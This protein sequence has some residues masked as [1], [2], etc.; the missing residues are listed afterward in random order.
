[1][2]PVVSRIRRLVRRP[3]RL[4]ER[5]FRD[6]F[7][8]LVPPSYL[9]GPPRK[10]FEQVGNRYLRHSVELGGLRP[11]DRVLDVGSGVGRIAIPLTGYLSEKGGYEGFDIIPEQVEW[12]RKH[13]TPRYPNFRFQLADVHNTHYHPAGRFRADEY[14]FPYDDES[15]DFVI[16]TSVF[17]HMRP[18]EVRRY[19]SEIARVLRTGRCCLITWFLLNEESRRLIAEGRARRTFSHEL[20]G[21]H[22]D[23]ADSPEA[24]IAFEE[25]AVHDL[26]RETELRIVEPIHYGGWCGRKQPLAGQDVVIAE[27][28]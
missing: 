24:A 3:I 28:A 1:M 15:F 11:D 18:P 2:P 9:Y 4:T 19:L 12:C 16:L 14:R 5:V 20:N 7:T 25:T 6:V 23:D 22:T 17:T 26:Y 21:F 10:S 8:P 13:I 27:K